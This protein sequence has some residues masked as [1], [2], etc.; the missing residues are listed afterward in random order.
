MKAIAT[1]SAVFLVI[2]VI[3]LIVHFMSLPPGEN[4]LI[5]DFHAHRSTYERLKLDLQAD[6]QVDQVSP[7]GI[8]DAT[9]SISHIPP[10][11][12]LSRARFDEY[13]S[14]LNEVHG[15]AVYRS[16]THANLCVG[17]WGR[18]FAGNT[19]HIAVCWLEDE[20]PGK[21]VSS[22]DNINWDAA[23][24]VGKRQFFYRKVEG[25]WY[26]ERDG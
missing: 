13:L 11:G 15:V 21:Q 22:I 6:G 5:A 26:L 25:H 16:H 3:V 20:V 17:M 14:L 23:D 1:I 10:Q 19:E 8:L 18:G 24:S 7:R 9:S 4:A 12:G 2:A